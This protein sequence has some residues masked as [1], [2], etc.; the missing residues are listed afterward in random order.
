MSGLC[1]S[2]FSFCCC[3]VRSVDSD[4]PFDVVA[5]DGA[6]SE[7]IV[8]QKDLELLQGRATMRPVELPGGI[9]SFDL[10][11]AERGFK[12]VDGR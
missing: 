9:R 2:H 7:E 11:G 1:A 12:V 3:R 6:V 8:S 5:G 10:T 4:G